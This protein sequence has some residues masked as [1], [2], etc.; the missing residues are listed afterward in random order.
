M[1]FLTGASCLE[2]RISCKIMFFLRFL[3]HY[4]R[5]KVK[6]EVINSPHSAARTPRV[7]VVRGWKTVSE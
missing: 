6:N 7:R 3:K 1:C 2:G 5:K 4:F